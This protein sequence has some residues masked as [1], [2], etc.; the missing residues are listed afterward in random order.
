MGHGFG[1]WRGHPHQRLQDPNWRSQTATT[2]WKDYSRTAG[3]T[4]RSTAA[5]ANACRC[6]GYGVSP[7][8][9]GGVAAKVDGFFWAGAHG[10]RG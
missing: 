10:T 7:S 9:G 1:D 5:V 2:G 8:V 6:V 3:W 4:G